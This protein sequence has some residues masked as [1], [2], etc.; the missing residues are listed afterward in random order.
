MSALAY[1]FPIPPEPGRTIEVAPG[2]H[3]LRLP[4]PFRLDHVNVYLLEAEDGWTIVDT[5]VDDARTRA[6]WQEVLRDRLGGK[7][8]RRILVTHFHPDHVGA[9]AFLCERTGAPLMMGETEYLTAKVHGL[10]GESDVAV[11]QGFYRRH[12]LGEAQLRAMAE[13][14]SRYT[15]TVPALPRRFEP[16]RAGDRLR[17]GARLFDVL[18]FA[19][20]APAQMLLH[21]RDG[22]V[23]LAADHILP[24]ISPNVSV[25]EDKPDDDPLGL[26]LESFG[27]IRSLVPDSVLVL[28]GHRLPFH[29]LA[30]RTEE[31]AAHHAERCGLI[32]EACRTRA[33]T[34]ADLVP[35]LFPMML[36]EHQLWFAFSE[37]LAHV[38][39]LARRGRLVGQ[40][41]AGQTL[42][43]APVA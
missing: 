19:G 1:P 31:L 14:L 34:V 30:A 39:Y 3:W 37:A 2:L 18:C 22:D 28:P 40:E 26:Y 41:R 8:V 42:W 12:G 15:R 16:L 25:A 29:G 7:P 6:L 20:H 9:A 11:E 13:R 33:L 5:G 32:V 35:A 38:N 10:A 43:S 23:L 17:I 36:D 4:L 24:Q 21:D 27:T